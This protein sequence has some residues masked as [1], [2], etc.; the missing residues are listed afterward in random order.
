MRVRFRARDRLLELP[1]HRRPKRLYPFGKSGI[2]L[3]YLISLRLNAREIAKAQ[4]LAA[5]TGNIQSPKQV[6]ICQNWHL[7]GACTTDGS[8]KTSVVVPAAVGV[9]GMTVCPIAVILGTSF[10]PW[11][12]LPGSFRERL[13]CIRAQ[14]RR[15]CAHLV[16]AV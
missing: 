8:A 5:S 11:E 13:W 10:G 1:G 4:A 3:A 2:N 15:R 16:A 12:R 6:L 9:R 7:C 14:W